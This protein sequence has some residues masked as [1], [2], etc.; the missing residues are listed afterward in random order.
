MEV[1]GDQAGPAVGGLP[2]PAPVAPQPPAPGSGSSSGDESE[3]AAAAIPSLR[4]M[5]EKHKR[6]VTTLHKLVHK[7]M[8]DYCASKW[9]AAGLSASGAKARESGLA[10]FYQRYG[11]DT[12]EMLTVGAFAA[13]ELK[14]YADVYVDSLHCKQRAAE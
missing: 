11:K 10:L 7:L 5:E 12:M 6:L 2:P 1:A 4:S 13:R 8:T 9:R 3:D 14:Q